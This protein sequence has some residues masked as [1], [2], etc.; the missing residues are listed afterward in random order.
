[1]TSRREYVVNDQQYR[2]A[3][4]MQAN[5]TSE[6]NLKN[7]MQEDK[8]RDVVRRLN[9]NNLLLQECQDRQR[10]TSILSVVAIIWAV[11]ALVIAIAL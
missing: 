4:H 1:M 2:A 3:E 5:R 10:L 9:R 11:I 6:S 8:L 7:A